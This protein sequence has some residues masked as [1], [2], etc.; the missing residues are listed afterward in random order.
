MTK[1]EEIKGKMRKKDQKSKDTD[2]HVV[3]EKSINTVVVGI[4]SGRDRI[5]G[6][7]SV[8]KTHF[9]FPSEST[10]LPLMEHLPEMLKGRDGNKDR[11]LNRLHYIR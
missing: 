5:I 9:G 8:Y 3:V 6:G 2:V 10:H 11:Y 7:S 4:N 1:N